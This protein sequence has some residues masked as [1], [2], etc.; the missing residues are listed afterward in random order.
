MRSPAPSPKTKSSNLSVG[1]DALSARRLSRQLARASTSTEADRALSAGLLHAQPRPDRQGPH[2]QA[3]GRTEGVRYG[4]HFLG[5]LPNEDPTKAVDKVEITPKK[6][7]VRSHHRSRTGCDPEKEERKEG[8]RDS[9]A[10]RQPVATAPTSGP[11]TAPVSQPR[12]SSPRP[13]GRPHACRRGG[14]ARQWEA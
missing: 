14:T 4:L 2:L 6:K 1:K 9:A 5:A 11:P 12:Q 3:Q 7:V 10:A 8:R 13:T